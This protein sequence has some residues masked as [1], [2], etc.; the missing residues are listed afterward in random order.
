M[1][2]ISNPTPIEN[3]IKIIHSLFAEG[4]TLFHIRKPDYTEEEMKV[5]LRQIGLEFR[6]RLVLHQHHHLANEFKIHRLHFSES[7]RIKNTSLTDCILKSIR[8]KKLI[9]STATHSIEDFNTLDDDF[10]YAFLS[11]LFSSISKKDYLSKLDFSIEIEKRTN[12]KTKL[13]ALG[14]IQ[15]ENI[16][17]AIAFGFDDVAL[18]GTIWNSNNP[19]ENFKLCQQTVLL[20]SL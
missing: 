15:F 20:H 10:Q 16:S 1:I 19:L 14:G 11:P 7:G 8:Q 2:V 9:I 5:F 4:L 12:H 13:I 18:L 3:E 17:Q 6:D